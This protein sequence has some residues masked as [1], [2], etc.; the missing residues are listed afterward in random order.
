MNQIPF[1]F[2]QLSLQMKAYFVVNTGAKLKK[3]RPK[4]LPRIRGTVKWF[5][6]TKGYGFIEP[7]SGGKDVFVH[8]SDIERSG[9]SGLSEDMVVSFEV[10]STGGREQA[11]SLALA[12]D[13]DTD[14]AGPGIRP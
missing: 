2:P 10:S 13:D 12:G 1:S 14:D 9:V 8:I 6:T 11:I 4:K 7:E 3:W 5:T